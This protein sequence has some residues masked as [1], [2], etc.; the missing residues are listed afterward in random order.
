MLSDPQKRAAYD[1]FGHAGAERPGTGGFDPSTFVGF[2]DIL[3]GLGDVFGLGD[4]FG[5]RPPPRRA[6]AGR[7]PALRHRDQLRRGRARHRDVHSVSAGRELRGLPRQRR[8]RRIRR[9]RVPDLSAGAD[10]CGISRASSPSRAPVASAA[11]TGQ[12]IAKPCPI[13]HGEGRVLKERKL[14]VKIP[15]GIATGQRLRIQGEGE[16]GVA[17]RPSRR[18]L[19]RRAGAGPRVPAREGNDLLCDMPLALPDA[20]ARR[21]D[22]GGD[23]ARRGAGAAEGARRAPHRDDVPAARQGAAGRRRAAGKGDLLVTVH[24]NDAEEVDEGAASGARVSSPS[25][26]RPRSSSRGRSGERRTTATSSI[27]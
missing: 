21:R 17:E 24:A 11:A 7:A 12:I 15:A 18:P 1:R 3:G 4:L 14:T 19:R 26:C 20:R 2:E 8:R 25:R 6:A 5:R 27:A 22:Q 16:S 23:A 13:C 10:S 9:R